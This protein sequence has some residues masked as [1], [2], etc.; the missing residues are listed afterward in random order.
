[1]KATA[2][3]VRVG[4]VRHTGGIS[5]AQ[6]IVAILLCFGLYFGYREY[7]E[8]QAK[9]VLESALVD[10]QTAQANQWVNDVRALHG[11]P[12]TK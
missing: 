2:D 7:K 1:M 6:L 10:I 3:Y 12:P 4:E 5:F 11:L 8:D 9:K